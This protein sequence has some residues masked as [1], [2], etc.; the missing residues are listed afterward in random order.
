MCLL[1]QLKQVTPLLLCILVTS[2]FLTVQA[3]APPPDGGYP[4]FTTRKGVTLSNI[5]PPGLA[6]QE[7][8][9]IRFLRTVQGT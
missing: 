2:G 4:G 6:T 1:T 8:G 3:V 5:S 7:L 9:G